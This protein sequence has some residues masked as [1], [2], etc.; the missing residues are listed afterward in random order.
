MSAKKTGNYFAR[1]LINSN[2]LVQLRIYDE[3]FNRKE[4]SINRNKLPP[5]EKGNPIK[6]IKGEQIPIDFLHDYSA[7]VIE[8]KPEKK[9]T[10]RS[11][12]R[13]RIN[14]ISTIKNNEDRFK[15][16]ITLTFKENISDID[17]SFK[18]FQNYIRRVKYILNKRNEELYYIAVPEFQKRGAIHFHLLASIEVGDIDLIPKRE[19]KVTFSRNNKCNITLIYYDLPQWKDN[20]YST[21]TAIYRNNDD[22]DIGLYLIKYLYKD[23]DNRFYS[24]QKV[25]KSQNLRKADEILINENDALE[26]IKTVFK[27]KMVS[28]YRHD[29]TSEYDHSFKELDFKLSS[30]EEVDYLYELIK[31]LVSNDVV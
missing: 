12:S 11:L 23:F 27:D 4:K 25:L 24:R 13:T 6:E 29:K 30:N 28:A 22:F 18:L 2:K 15:S 1:I 5:K 16:F 20:G 10:K 21:A 26:A 14:I 31:A 19:P 3:T 7:D 9:I 8:I 17:E